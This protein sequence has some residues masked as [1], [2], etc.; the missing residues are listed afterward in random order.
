MESLAQLALMWGAVYLAFLAASKTRL[1]HVLW[2]LAF[3]TILVNIGLLPEKSD[4]FIRTLSELG[5]ILIMFA[6][7][8]EEQTGNFISSI[9]KSWGIA[10]FG[11]LGPFFTAYFLAEWFWGQYNISIMCGLAMTATAVSLTM[12][13]L[14]G[15]GLGRSLAATRIMTSAVLDDIASLAALA[16]M[17]PIATGE[18]NFE[19]QSILYTIGKAILFFVAVTIMGKWL[20]PRITKGWL[21]KLPVIGYHGIADLI[22][23]A[24]GQHSVLTVLLLALLVGILAHHF[25]FHPAVG[26][27]MAGLILKE[28]Y[29]LH[30]DDD[31]LYKHTSR[32]V[33]IVAFSIF[34]PVF[35][36]N[37]GSK[38]VFDWHVLVSIIPHTVLLTLSLF[39]VQVGSASIAARYTSGMN[40][41]QSLMIGFG[42]LGRAELAFVVMDI[43]YLENSIL[44]TEA[45]YT[46]M[47]TAFWLNVAVPVTISLWKPVYQRHSPECLDRN[48]L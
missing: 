37:L 20:L 34:G 2:Y 4:D 36:V 5:I 24:R 7:G 29:F 47:L 35:F 22:G 15:E 12:V 26:A 44:S 9:K 46:L 42:M 30:P 45:F 11:A 25:G 28:E 40:W 1:T 21:G 17:V 38:L 41:V 33:D 19:L 39:I 18:A 31:K 16:I 13:S 32:V 23:M 8:F 3:G 48:R 10:L 43:A 14:K 6:L 27:Y